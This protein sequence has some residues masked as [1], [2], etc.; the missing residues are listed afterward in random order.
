MNDMPVTMCSLDTQLLNTILQYE[1]LVH[2]GIMVQ[3]EARKTQ[4]EL[5]LKMPETDDKAYQKEIE[6][7]L[8]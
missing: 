7:I 5:E 8:M 6:D 3:T 2:W 1:H 4:S